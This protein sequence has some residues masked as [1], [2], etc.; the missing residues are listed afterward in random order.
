MHYGQ[1]L[2]AL[3]LKQLELLYVDAYEYEAKVLAAKK[4]RK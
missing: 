4:R 1:C 3:D 2:A